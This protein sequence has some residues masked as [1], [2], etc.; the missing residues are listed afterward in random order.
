MSHNSRES[1][2]FHSVDAAAV[3][4]WLS[5]QILISLC[6]HTQTGFYLRTFH[7][8]IIFLFALWEADMVTYKTT[9]AVPCLPVLGLTTHTPFSCCLSFSYTFLFQSICV[10]A[11]LF[12]YEH[13]RRPWVSG[14]LAGNWKLSIWKSFTVVT[15]HFPH[16]CIWFQGVASQWHIWI[17]FPDCVWRKTEWRIKGGR[18][19]LT[20]WHKERPTPMEAILPARP[21]QLWLCILSLSGPRGSSVDEESLSGLWIDNGSVVTW[22]DSCQYSLTSDRVK[23][24]LF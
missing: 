3:V 10:C 13:V 6:K 12:L 1:L 17:S 2:W 18:S 7:C 8:L 22:S 20:G 4:K 23:N 16:V 5:I 21:R 24:L 19:L 9:V 15:V 11:F 14:K